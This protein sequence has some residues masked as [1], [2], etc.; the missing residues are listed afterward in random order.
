MSYAIPI[1]TPELG[2]DD[3]KQKYEIYGDDA[4]VTIYAVIYRQQGDNWQPLEEQESASQTDNICHPLVYTTARQIPAPN[5]FMLL[6]CNK[7]T[8]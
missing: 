4:Q 8:H 5:Y 3:Q 2:S 1:D 6:K 7:F